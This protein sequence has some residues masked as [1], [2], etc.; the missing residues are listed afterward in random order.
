MITFYFVCKNASHEQAAEEIVERFE[1]DMPYSDGLKMLRCI[2][3]IFKD[4]LRL[5]RG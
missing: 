5:P 1:I 2:K 3:H 4:W